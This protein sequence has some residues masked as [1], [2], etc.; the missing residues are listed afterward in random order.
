M[1][2]NIHIKYYNRKFITCDVIVVGIFYRISYVDLFVC[3]LVYHWY[4][5]WSIV[6]SEIPVKVLEQFFSCDKDYGKAKTV[7]EVKIFFPP[8]AVLHYDAR[9]IFE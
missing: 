3:F 2:F 7:K 6:L 1:T 8:N 9:D 4:S 5:Q